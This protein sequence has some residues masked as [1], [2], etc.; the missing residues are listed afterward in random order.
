MQSSIGRVKRRSGI[1]FSFVLIFG[2]IAAGFATAVPT[3]AAHA[4]EHTIQ[5]ML[6]LGSGADARPIADVQLSLK[7]DGAQLETTQSDSN[8]N[9][10][11]AVA[12]TGE[13]EIELA[14][15][16][17]P[18]GV[19]LREG[20]DP[21]RTVTVLS[22]QPTFVIFALESGDGATTSPSPDVDDSTAAAP[23]T[24]Q[25]N[26]LLTLLVEGIIFGIV[27]AMAAVGLSLIYGVTR[28]VNFAHGEFVSL[29]ALLALA[30]NVGMFG[31]QLPLWLATVITVVLVGALGGAMDIFIF[32]RLAH[33]VQEHFALLIFTIGLSFLMRHLLL[34]FFGAESLPYREYSL[35]ELIHLGPISIAPRDLA[36]IGIS[37]VV[38]GG[39][40]A[41]IRWSRTGQAMRALA[42]NRALAG[43][44][45]IPAKV[46][47]RNVWIVGSALAALGGVLFAV[48]QQARWNMGFDLLMFLFAAVILG[49]LGTAFGTIVGGLLVGIAAQVSTLFL[50]TELKSAFAMVIL[51]VVL[52]FRPEGLFN[53]RQRLG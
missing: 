42:D 9:W 13:Y 29:G 18:E 35:Q 51:A 50:P 34:F 39:L 12:E 53:R 37:V 14:T 45:G 20:T 33:R 22:G 40:G 19:A 23:D 24:Q 25:G 5:G 28:I 16:T 15:D 32:R 30:F 17:L 4:A 31:V 2:F 7:Q 36:V 43:E 41:M 1:L 21:S 11:F 27:I 10:A 46:V 44:T 26:R 8:G 48:S 49:G 38:L 3:E 47:E 6:K 52:L